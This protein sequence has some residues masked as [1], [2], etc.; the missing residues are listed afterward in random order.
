MTRQALIACVLVPLILFGGR[1]AAA[2]SEVEALRAQLR[3]TVLQLRELQDQQA[4]AGS[5]STAASPDAAALQA[6]LAA[7]QRELRAARRSAGAAAD[8]QAALTK[9]QAD[10]AGLTSAAAAS[11]AELD[12]YK[13]VYSQAAQAGR[14]LTA[15]RDRLK[16]QLTLTGN[17]AAACQAKNLR[18]VAFAEDLLAAYGKVGFLQVLTAREPVIGL[19]R[20]QLENIAQDREDTIRANRCDARLDAAAPAKQPSAAPGG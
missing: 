18:L 11:A 15:E 5:P 13:S 20:V 4:A 16:A 3:S 9:A 17:V 12:K 6:K 14:D 19:R 2:D 1:A 8:L 10:N 7:A